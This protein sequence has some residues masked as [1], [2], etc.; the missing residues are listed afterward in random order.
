MTM[1]FVFICA[2]TAAGEDSLYEMLGIDSSAIDSI[3]LGTIELPEDS[4]EISYSLAMKLLGAACGQDADTT[5][6]ILKSA[7]FEI[8]SQVNY[9]KSVSDP[10]HSCAYTIAAGNVQ[11]SGEEIEAVLISI[12]GTYAGEWYSNFDFCPSHSEEALFADNFLLAAMEIFNELDL[13]EG[14]PVIV[15][16]HSRGAAV[17]NLLGVM[18]DE[19]YGDENVYVYTFASPNTVK[20]GALTRSYNNIF[21]FINPCDLVPQLPLAA[22][23]YKRAGQDIVLTCDDEELEELTDR[24]ESVLADIAPSVSDY[25]NERHSLTAADETDGENTAEW[26][27]ESFSL[28]AYDMM[29]MLSNVLID[30]IYSDD[31]AADDGE[32]A[33]LVEAAEVDDAGIAEAVE[34]DDS[35]AT[36]LVEAAEADAAEAADVD[37]AENEKAE[38]SEAGWTDGELAD[39]ISEDSDFYSL[40]QLAEELTADGAAIGLELLRAHLPTSYEELLTKQ[41]I[42]ET[43]KGL[44]G[45]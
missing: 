16:G 1:C 2:Q 30:A 23:G 37:D 19:R 3:D 34:A 38:D 24:Y 9:D 20:D 12:R 45:A 41:L 4:E 6:K 18:L 39:I 33:E 21:N 7:D 10:D 35:E 42:I 11:R 44:L 31:D 36:A 26:E 32:A 27:D 15:T 14:R 29:I 13:L 8:V 25:Y 28:T 5:E 43:L 17:A 22:W 40:V